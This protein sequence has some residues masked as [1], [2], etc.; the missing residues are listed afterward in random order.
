ME[1]NETMGMAKEAGGMSPSKGDSAAA[2]TVQANIRG[3][4][5][6]ARMAKESLAS[7]AA[8][9]SAQTNG[10]RRRLVSQ[11]DVDGSFQDPQDP[12]CCK[13]LDANFA[14]S[15]LMLNKKPSYQ[16]EESA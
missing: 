13:T 1:S 14:H 7:S 12:T 5:A 3:M 6:R 10:C 8:H 9:A 16:R 2:R 15:D 4:Q 11:R